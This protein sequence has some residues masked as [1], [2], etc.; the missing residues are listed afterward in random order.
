MCWQG[1]GVLLANQRNP[2]VI[3]SIL[4]SQRPVILSEVLATIAEGAPD[5]LRRKLD[6]NP[7]I[8]NEWDWSRDAETW[9]IDAGN[10]QVRLTPCKNLLAST[11]Q[12]ACSCLLSPRCFHLLSVL[13]VLGLAEAHG[14]ETSPD[15]EKDESTTS[16]AEAEWSKP[17]HAAAEAMWKAAAAILA[18]GARAAGTLLQSHLLRAIHECRSQGL[19]R[20]AAAGLRVMQNIRLLREENEAF[21][22]EDLLSDLTELLRVAWTLSQ[23]DKA[24]GR[25]WLGIARRKFEPAGSLR[26]RGLFTEP[27]LTRSGYSGVVTYLLAEDETIFSVSNVRPGTA[28]RISEAYQTGADVG[29]LSVPHQTLNRQGLLMQKAT[30]SADGRLGGGKECRAI[31]IDSAG[32]D[33]EAITR[34]FATPLTD[35]V[36]RVFDSDS[37][38]PSEQPA[39]WDLLFLSGTILGSDGENLL[40]AQGDPQGI[41]RL[42]IA[43]DHPALAFRENL[44]FLARLPGLAIRCMARMVLSSPGDALA[45]AFSPVPDHSGP[46]QLPEEWQ[47]VVN[48]GIDKLERGFFRKA[49]RQPQ[50]VETPPESASTADGLDFVRRRLQAVALG[51]RHALPT[52]RM[53]AAVSDARSLDA[54]LQPTAAALLKGLAQCAGESR[55]DLLGV[56]FPPDPT[57]LAERWLAGAIY[58]ETARRHFQKWNWQRVGN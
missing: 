23:T 10:E 48:L 5:R 14:V 42:R 2:L 56:R 33:S 29:G 16:K 12:I 50:L 49:Q 58:E 18:T 30:R 55:T 41:I 43:N 22:T 44:E 7:T 17:Q 9:T 24:P 45:L 32:W 36:Q 46:C 57:H 1:R 28:S 34:R 6:K 31:T 39:G 54:N 25:E 27:I 19:H 20:L 8:A 38:V 4:M 26:L 13:S 37:P 40:L 53:K 15:T 21:R 51:G 3:Y 47:G 52:G 11:D 35:Q